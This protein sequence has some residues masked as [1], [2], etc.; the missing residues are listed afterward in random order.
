MFGWKQKVLIFSCL[1]AASGALAGTS[2]VVLNELMVDPSPGVGLPEVEYVELMNA[3]AHSVRLEGWALWYGGR[4]FTLPS[5]VL[6]A[7]GYVVFCKESAHALLDTLLSVSGLSSFPALS[8][9]GGCLALL[10]AG[11]GVESVVRYSSDGYGSGFKAQGGWS[12]ECRDPSNASGDAANWTASLD[13][14]GGTPGRL[15]SVRTACPDLHPPWCTALRVPTSHTVVLHFSKTMDTTSLKEEAHYALSPEKAL[16]SSVS[17]AFPEAKAVTLTLTDA[18]EAKTMYAL[19][20]KGLTDV[21]GFALPDTVLGLA[22]PEEPRAGELRLNEVLFNPKPGG[23]DYVE[24]VNVSDRCVD[25]SRVILTRRLASG[26]LDKGCRWVDVPTPCLPGS[27]WL[28][29]VSLDSV[30]AAGGFPRAPNGLEL[31]A[32]PSLPDDEGNVVLATLSGEIVDEMTYTEGMHLAILEDVEGIALEK[33]L[34]MLSSGIPEH[35]VSAA[36]TAHYGT[37]GYPNSH[38]SVEPPLSGGRWTANRTWLT[39]NNDGREDEVMLRLSS[40]LPCVGNLR[41]YDLSGKLVRELMASAL[42]GAEALCY[43]DGTDGKGQRVP[44]GR[45]LLL[46]ELFT[47]EGQVTTQKMVLTV[48]F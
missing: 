8:N 10:N 30:Y 17:V 16:V 1:V 40:E 22:L 14:S 43:W 12:L 31:S 6:P 37:P 34:P 38:V 19:S 13:A 2:G 29:A 25:L 20:L 28:L 42:L 33:R 15:N 44:Y 27:Y 36:S 32:L 5:V 35:W 39:P 23:C 48:L 11:G 21:S 9:A 45:Y 18:L 4:T 41:V 47:T 24:V 46:A 3:S 26:L 7:Q